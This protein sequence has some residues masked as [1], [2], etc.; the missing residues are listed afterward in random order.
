MANLALLAVVFHSTVRSRQRKRE[1]AHLREQLLE[2]ERKAR[3]AAEQANEAKS[4][5]LASMSHEL[6]TPLNA[7][8]GYSEMVQ[9]GR[10]IAPKARDRSKKA[11]PASD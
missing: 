8:I 10:A 7:I 4:Q 5:F 11:R 1:A 9:E 3:E 6:R 2:E